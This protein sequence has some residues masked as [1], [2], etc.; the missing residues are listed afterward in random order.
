MRALISPVA[1]SLVLW[2]SAAD[3]LVKSECVTPQGILRGLVEILPNADTERSKPCVGHQTEI[4]TQ[5]MDVFPSP[6]ARQ[7]GL[8]PASA[9]PI[10]VEGTTANTT[11]L[12]TYPE[13]SD[14]D[15]GN[16]IGIVLDITRPDDY[17]HIGGFGCTMWFLNADSWTFDDPGLINLSG[18]PVIFAFWDHFPIG[19]DQI[20]DAHGVT[21]VDPAP[22]GDARMASIPVR[23]ALPDGTIFRFDDATVSYNAMG[24]KGCWGSVRVT[25]EG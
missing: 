19:M 17:D 11:W 14:R 9:D 4:L 25:I 6:R 23:I 12:T 1:L 18:R 2:S 8:V 21:V 7:L 15:L 20:M 10:L 24:K 13:Y 5:I 22:D 3:A 16:S